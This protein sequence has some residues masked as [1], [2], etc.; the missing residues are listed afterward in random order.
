MDQAHPGS[1]SWCLG[2][3]GEEEAGEGERL[4]RINRLNLDHDVQLTDIRMALESL[5]LDENWVLDRSMR[6]RLYSHRRSGDET[7]SLIPDA[8]F[9]AT[10]HTGKV[11]AIAVECELHPK[12][13]S[14]YEKIFRAYHARSEIS[15]VWY[16]VN[17]RSF[18]NRLHEKWGEGMRSRSNDDA[19][20]GVSMIDEVLENPRGAPIYFWGGKNAIQQFFK[21]PK[22]AHSIITD[23]VRRFSTVVS[24]RNGI[25]AFFGSVIVCQRTGAEEESS[26]LFHF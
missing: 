8:I 6:R 23:G 15:M 16:F 13:L 7:R 3:Q 10:T 20:F 18:G 21:L 24:A 19:S 1:C 11:R 4:P 2:V 9:S 12:K 22:R 5:G 25:V 17:S 26:A 14:R